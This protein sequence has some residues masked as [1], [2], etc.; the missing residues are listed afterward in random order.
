MEDARYSVTIVTQT[1]LL[2]AA[3]GIGEIVG[4]SLGRDDDYNCDRGCG[5]CR[6]DL[7]TGSLFYEERVRL[8]S[9]K[10]HRPDRNPVSKIPTREAA[11]CRRGLSSRRSCGRSRVWL[12]SGQ[13]FSLFLRWNRNTNA[14]SGI[15][16]YSVRFGLKQE[17]PQRSNN[18]NAQLD[19]DGFRTRPL[20]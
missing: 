10:R 19:V 18:N 7:P 1:S 3:G 14:T 20:F 2:L 12:I 15:D 8:G 11:A 16:Q 17:I 5:Y 13:P 6:G 9:R 4:Q